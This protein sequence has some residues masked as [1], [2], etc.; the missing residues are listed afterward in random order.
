MATHKAA[1][2]VTIAPVAEKS[3]L[4]LWVERYWKLGL[5]ITLAVTA[6]ILYRVHSTTTQR[7]EDDQS[8]DRLL[9]LTSED[10]FSRVLTGSSEELRGVANQVRGKQAGAWALFL[11]ASSAAEA[12]EPDE[13]R[14]ALDALRSGYPNHPLLRNRLSF[15][16]HPEPITA[17]EALEVRVEAMRR[18]KTANSSLFVAPEVAPD[19]PRVTIHTDLGDIVVGLYPS[20]APQ[21]VENFLKLAR[22]GY[23][24]GTRFHRVIPGFMIQ[25]GDPNTIQGDPSTWGQGGPEAKIPREPNNLKHFAGMLAA[26]K[27]DRETESSGSQFYITVGPAHHLDG[28]HVVFGRVLA[29]MDVVHAIERTPVDP[30]SL[31][32]PQVPPVV[33]SMEVVG[34]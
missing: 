1:T 7:L 12:Q 11:A 20:E 30:L 15:P 4:A 10:R 32:R 33:R 26:A 27:K 31:D 23:Y 2:A 14:L 29:G 13:A 16:G 17:A 28:E 18:W 24:A 25:G 19:A 9:A 8:W 21:H 3:G 34:G 5:L 22:E 6:L